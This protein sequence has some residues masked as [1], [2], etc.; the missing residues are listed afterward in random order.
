LHDAIDKHE[1]NPATLLWYNSPAESREQV[2]PLGNGLLGAK[3]FVRY[4]E[5]G[6]LQEWSEDFVRMAE[7][8][9][10]KSAKRLNLHHIRILTVT[11]DRYPVKS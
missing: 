4:G 1:F 6:T 9:H 5:D 2:L 3:V 8:T 10:Y 7:F 11:S